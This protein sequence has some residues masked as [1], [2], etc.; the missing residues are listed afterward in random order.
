MKIILSDA[1]KEFQKK[2][3]FNC[4]TVNSRTT[5]GSCCRTLVSKVEIGEPKSSL[6]HYNI[7]NEQGLIL[8]ISKNLKLENNITF[9]YDKMLGREMLEMHGYLIEHYCDIT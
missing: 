5:G 1:F 2:K 7:F 4:V 8:Y 6:D 3:N 9:T